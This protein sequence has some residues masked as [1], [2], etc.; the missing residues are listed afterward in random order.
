MTFPHPYAPR[1]VWL[2]ASYQNG[3]FH[4]IRSALEMHSDFFFAHEGSAQESLVT[5]GLRPYKK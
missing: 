5:S 4:L 2:T 3:Q 1:V